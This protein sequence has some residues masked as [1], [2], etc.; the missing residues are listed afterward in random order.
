[1]TSG[2]YVSDETNSQDVRFGY[3]GNVGTTL[4]SSLVFTVNG[5]AI[6]SI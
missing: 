1:M 5:P 3:E 2:A 4:T 6:G